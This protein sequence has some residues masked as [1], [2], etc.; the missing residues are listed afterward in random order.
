MTH[1]RKLMLEELQGRNFSSETIRRY[2]SAVE[3]F[4]VTSANGQINWV[5]TTA[6]RL[7]C[8]EAFPMKASDITIKWCGFGPQ[9]DVDRFQSAST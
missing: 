8:A 7:S 4:R 2:I 5:P 1:L 9:S 3:R 6:P